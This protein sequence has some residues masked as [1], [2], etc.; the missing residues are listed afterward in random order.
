[1]VL[2]AYGGPKGKE[3]LNFRH[4]GCVDLR[5]EFC[6]SPE[7]LIRIAESLVYQPE[8]RSELRADYLKSPEEAA[9]ISGFTVLTPTILPE[10]FVFDHGTYD[11]EL[12][13]IQTFIQSN[14]LRILEP[15]SY[16]L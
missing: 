7:Q 6:T 8:P 2:I 5:Y 3:N 10:G 14:K 15:L 12:K 1:M 9:L 4:D 13:Q 16:S 11:A